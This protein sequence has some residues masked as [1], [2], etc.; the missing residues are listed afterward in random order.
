M[1]HLYS[2]LLSLLLFSPSVS[3][4]PELQFCRLNV[5]NSNLS[6]NYVRAITKDEDGF[7]WIATTNGLNRY[8]GHST[9]VYYQG[10]FGLE[11][12]SVYALCSDKSNVLWLKSNNSTQYY[13]KKTGMFVT[14]DTDLFDKEDAEAKRLK[15]YF[16]KDL[17]S[18]DKYPGL[19]L[20]CFSSDKDGNLWVGTNDGIYVFDQST[21]SIQHIHNEKDL[22]SL[23]DNRITD[24]YAGH[25]GEIWVGTRSGVF[26]SNRISSIFRK[27]TYIN[28][29]SLKN[30]YINAFAP[31]NNGRIWISTENAGIF[32]YDIF[33][34]KVMAF[35][36][37]AVPRRCLNIRI[38]DRNLWI[39]TARGVVRINLD[40]NSSRFFSE[41]AEYKKIGYSRDV[42]RTRN[43]KVFIGTHVGLFMLDNE[44]DQ[45]HT[46]EA[47]SNIYFESLL[48]DSSGNLWGCTSSKGVF[49]INP[50]DLTY[51]HYNFTYK[52][53]GTLP[54]SRIISAY[55][56]S[57]GTM[58]FC[59][60]GKGICRLNTSDGTFTVYNSSTLQKPNFN[61][62]CYSVLEDNS[63][64]LWIAT[65][66]GIIRFNP[67][68]RSINCFTKE[69]G[70]LNSENGPAAKFHLANDDI[71]YGSADGFTVFNATRLSQESDN[72][73]LII[74]DL[75]VNGRKVT[76]SDE[77]GILD[78]H[79]DM[80]PKLLLK[81]SQNSFDFT[82]SVTG[83]SQSSPDIEYRLTGY[84]DIWQPAGNPDN[85][86]SFKNIPYGKYTLE[87]H[88]TST[89][90]T[91]RLPVHIDVPIFLRWWAF[92]IYSLL[93]AGLITLIL[94]F[95]RQRDKRNN[96]AIIAEMKYRQE[97]SMLEEKMNFLA[98]IVHEIKTPLTLIK[99]PLNAIARNYP[100]NDFIKNNL[101]VIDN[102]TNHLTQLTNEM[103]E[104]LR[105]ERKGYILENKVLDITAVVNEI[106]FNFKERATESEIDFRYCTEGKPIYVEA[107]MASLRKI[108]N[109]LLGNAFKYCDR[110]IDI[111]IRIREDRNFCDI[112]F[113]NDG[114]AIPPEWRERIFKP[115]MR[116]DGVKLNESDGI[117]LGLPLARSLAELN[118][119]SLHLNTES[120]LTEF[121]LSLPCA[122]VPVAEVPEDGEGRFSI[123][124]AEDNTDLRSYIADQLGKEYNVFTVSD[125]SAAVRC[126][127][128]HNIDLLISD[129][130]MPVMNGI[131]LCRSVRDNFDISHVMIIIISGMNDLSLKISSIESG[132]NLYIEKPLDIEYLK[133]C[134]KNLLEHRKLLQKT[135]CNTLNVENE[136]NFNLNK[137]D[138]EFIFKIES[139]VMANISNPAYSVT[140]LEEALFMS[141][142]T[143]LRKFKRLLNTTPNSYIRTKRLIMAAK[144]LRD[145]ESRISEVCFTCGFNTT[146]YFTKCFHDYYGCSPQTY[147]QNHSNI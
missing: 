38:F 6:H 51:K 107:D 76:C 97:K 31:D 21:K 34:G 61:D 70:L 115:F 80:C 87:I 56:S 100:D 11:S 139:E 37:A 68:N 99:S 12:S 1:K 145:G 83:S 44:T 105:L 124:I 120:E 55:E 10:D 57:D 49:C 63:G 59:T 67:A 26:Y 98:N 50:D 117:G 91:R 85:R 86:I 92:I 75:Y 114:E 2:F 133:V 77:S 81:S 103:L 17:K 147:Q 106:C 95:I 94:W 110:L 79:I 7:I 23:S 128:K 22:F 13:D 116:T 113:R 15:E 65:N 58:W 136:E 104:Y 66:K 47:L 33:S 16:I 60:F 30:A 137:A 39:V 40:S 123:L 144:M 41:T 111:D 82:I 9:S 45:L 52:Q 53:E 20:N 84:S 25:P 35:R 118:S 73:N 72:I 48:C 64:N 32:I 42:C 135:L 46:V 14:A 90:I 109:N 78:T 130:A 36:N 143:L 129:I 125:G 101:K 126:M 142:A 141:S 5:E 8:D 89:G 71:F 54:A 27:I 131:E 132:A 96:E 112:T 62:I 3:A 102:S 4:V 108:I 119:G 29:I 19:H 127:H 93:V 88:E 122:P 69:D 146:T 28:D 138:R 140:Q 18:E 134:I 74:N 43:G 24:I 121:V